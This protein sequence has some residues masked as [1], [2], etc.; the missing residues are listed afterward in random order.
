MDFRI[1]EGVSCYEFAGLV[2]VGSTESGIVIVRPLHVPAPLVHFPDSVYFMHVGHASVKP[3]V[4]SG[5]GRGVEPCRRCHPVE[6]VNHDD[7]AVFRNPAFRHSDA[8]GLGRET[9][10]SLVES[11]Y[12]V[13]VYMAVPDVCLDAQAAVRLAGRFYYAAV[14]ETAVVHFRVENISGRGGGCL[15]CV[16]GRS[17]AQ[18]RFPSVR[19]ES[20]E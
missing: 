14:V 10:S 2:G 20:R 9:T 12:L 19:G 13:T 16:N 17:P 6:I 3:V 18:Y 8:E 4:E 11:H 1:V 5:I 7:R 15:Q